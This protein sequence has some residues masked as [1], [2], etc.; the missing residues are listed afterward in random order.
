MRLIYLLVI[1][2]LPAFSKSLSNFNARLFSN[3]EKTGLLKFRTDFSNQRFIT[4]GIKV[5]FR[6]NKN[7]DYYCEAVVLSKTARHFLLRLT[8]KKKCYKY[9][10]MSNGVEGEFVSVDF[11][12]NIETTN[13]LVR[14][15]NK[16]RMAIYG[17]L[18]VTKKR[19]DS[20]LERT[21]SVNAR[22]D[23]LRD[24]LEVERQEAL[25]YLESERLLDVQ[26]YKNYTARLDEIDFKLER[27][28]VED[29]NSVDQR[30]S[31]DYSRFDLE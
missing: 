15:L 23:T 12:R 29:S 31:L 5:K 21:N 1:F 17:K 7:L 19:L 27:Y 9:Q 24:K 28:K 4:P 14:I 10:N 6:T 2:C 25:N 22:Y 20:F 13:E 18:K 16:K 26:N 30:W 8:H 3:S 11:E